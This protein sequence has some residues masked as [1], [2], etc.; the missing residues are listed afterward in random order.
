MPVPVRDCKGLEAGAFLVCAVGDIEGQFVGPVR[1][2]GTDI[3]IKRGTKCTIPL[4]YKTPGIE[5]S[6]EVREENYWVILIS[7]TPY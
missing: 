1:G 2:E 3:K 7:L 6:S 4:K 5:A